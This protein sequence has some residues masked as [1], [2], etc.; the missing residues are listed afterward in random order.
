MKIRIIQ[1]ENFRSF[2][3]DRPVYLRTAC[4]PA[5][6]AAKLDDF[7]FHD[8][9]HTTAS[10]LP[11]NGATPDEIA[12]V[13]GHRTLAMVKHCAH[14]S[15]AHVAGVLARTNAKIFGGT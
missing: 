10:Y 15:D 12:P 2:E 14:R 13:L 5:V 9:R 4:A 8:L 6:K 11:M 1:L 3:N 7:H